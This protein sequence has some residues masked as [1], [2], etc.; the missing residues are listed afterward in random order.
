MVD[1]QKIETFLRAAENSSLSEAAKQLHLSQPTVSHH[2]KTLEQELDVTL[3]HRSNMG[4]QL[5]EA[6]RLLLPWARRLMHD[7]NDLK[8]MMSSLQGDIVGELRIACSTT[9]G[10]YILP[11]MA[12]R[13]SQ[14]YPG[15]HI[16]ILACGPEQAALNLLDG[17][18]HLGVVSTEVD[19]TSLESQKFFRDV[20]TLIVASRHRWAFR[21]IIDPAELLEEPII[22]REETSGTRRVVLAE[23]AKHDISQ[24]DLNIFME[25][26]NAEAIVR[27]VAAGYGIS[28][29]SSLA[30]ACPLER[31]N[32]TDVDVEG[33]TLERNVYMVRKRVS[34]PHR[35]R[36]VFWSFI[37]DPAN[38]DILRLA[39][40]PHDHD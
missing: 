16:R 24:D 12:A 23:M 30:S 25:L 15:I 33:M 7:T 31:G 28:F 1:I 32:V 40:H 6:G 29:V 38:A 3:F 36:D 13:F 22:M 21:K 18:A 26:G 11:Q 10:K 19:D 14:Q 17:E 9:A 2:I 8:E 39:H 4:L 20:I 5:T 35:P 37:H 27:T 34:S